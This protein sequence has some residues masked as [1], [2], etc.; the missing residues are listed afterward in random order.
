MRI[1]YIA[2]DGTQFDDE[3]SCRDYEWKLNHPHLKEIH[4]FDKDGKEFENIFAE[5][6]Y[7]Y[8]EKIIVETDIAAKELQEL[9]QYTGYCSYEDIDKAGEWRYDSKQERFVMR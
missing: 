4:A 1:I 5:D 9:G 2:D 6:T 3:W 8:S 7:N